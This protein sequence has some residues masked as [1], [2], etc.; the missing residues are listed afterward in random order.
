MYKAQASSVS[1]NDISNAIASENVTYSAGNIS[2]F[3]MKRSIR[4]QGQ[5]TNMDVIRNIVIKS[6]SGASVYLKDVAEVK[7]T[8]KEQESFSRL[9]GQNVITLNVVKKSGK[10]LL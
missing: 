1:F 2:T 6:S 8:F 4:V 7:D 5:F 10:N 9:N 3:G